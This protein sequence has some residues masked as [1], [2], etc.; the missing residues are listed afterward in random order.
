MK[1][2]TVWVRPWCLPAGIFAMFISSTM[3]V[4][5]GWLGAP[6]ALSVAGIAGAVWGTG[7]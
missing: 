4:H 6:L 5:S 7:E 1:R 2:L 3:A